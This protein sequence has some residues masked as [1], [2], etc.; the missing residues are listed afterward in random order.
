MLLWVTLAFLLFLASVGGAIWW[1]VQS[2]LY[3]K[4]MMDGE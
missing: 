2:D 3:D 1:K 4:G